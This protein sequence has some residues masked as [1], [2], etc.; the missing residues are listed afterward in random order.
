M[1][2]SRLERIRQ[3]ERSHFWFRGREALI[4]Q[5]LLTRV[6]PPAEIVDLGCGTGRIAEL[7][8]Q[9]GFR[10]LGVDLHPAPQCVQANIEQ[11]PLEENSCDLAL[12]LDV[13]EHVDDQAALQ[14]A[15]R[16]VRPG[17][18]VI[19]TVPAHAWL[20]SQRD[21]AAGHRRRYSRK[22]V[23]HLLQNA[24][25]EI[26]QIGYFQCLLFPL[27]ILSRLS[28]RALPQTLEWE[29]QTDRP[30]LTQISLF[31][32][33]LARHLPLPFGSTLFAIGKKHATL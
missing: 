31:E 2:L 33:R 18:W 23:Q 14:E 12:L 26:E 20:W 7:L 5:L 17:G 28:S 15:C 6:A 3:M 10:T 24:S 8:S 9:K 4:E 32:A 1:D 27:F 19:L 11:L 16:I 22:M 21:E 13:L 25:L 29:E 30:F